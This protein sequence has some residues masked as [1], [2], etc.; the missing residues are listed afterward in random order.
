MAVLPGNNGGMGGGWGEMGGMGEM[1][2]WGGGDAVK[3]KIQST[4]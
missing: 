4:A 1:G 2:G 3:P